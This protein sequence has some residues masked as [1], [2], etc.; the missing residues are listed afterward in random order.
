MGYDSF[1]EEWVTMLLANHRPG[2]MADRATV[3]PVIKWVV[4]KRSCDEL[5]LG[6]VSDDD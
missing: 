5:K 6:R 1:L 2:L 3:T 4:L